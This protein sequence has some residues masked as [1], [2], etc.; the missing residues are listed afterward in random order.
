MSTYTYTQKI[1]DYLLEDLDEKAEDL[2]YLVDEY[3][4]KFES[5]PVGTQLHWA[6]E[7]ETLADEFEATAEELV[8]I[9]LELGCGV[10]PNQVDPESV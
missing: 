6:D 7:S 1:K 3:R 2:D 9:T 8:Q 4:E 5:I 10:Y